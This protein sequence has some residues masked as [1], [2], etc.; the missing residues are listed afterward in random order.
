MKKPNIK[1]DQPMTD[2]IRDDILIPGSVRTNHRVLGYSDLNFAL[3][4]HCV[5][6][7]PCG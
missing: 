4:L 2:S 7:A 1:K 5:G 6:P 3:R